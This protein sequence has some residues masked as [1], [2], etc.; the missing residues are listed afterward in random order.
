MILSWYPFSY[1]KLKISLWLGHL[2]KVFQFLFL[3]QS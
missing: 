3:H 2:V 1:M